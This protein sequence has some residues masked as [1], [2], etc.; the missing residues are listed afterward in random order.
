MPEIELKFTVAPDRAT[1]VEA[2]LRRAGSRLTRIESRYFDTADGRLADARLSL[3]L[4]RAEGAWE[5]T[6]KAAGPVSA[7]RDEETVLRTGDWGPDGPPVDPSL[8][9]G[10]AAGKALAKALGRPAEP[11]QQAY[12]SFVR[13]R[14]IEVDCEGSRVEVAFDQG[15][16][17]SG[18]H[19]LPVCEVEYEL[20]SGAPAA[21]AVLARAGVVEHGM[22]LSTLAK[23][24]RGDRLFRGEPRRLARKGSRPMLTPSLAGP[25]ML[26][27]MLRACLEQVLAN[28]SEIA[29]DRVDDEL[30]HQLR[31]GLRRLRTTM[32]ELGSLAPALGT[33]WELPVVG[34][35]QLLGA[36]RDR[37]AVATALQARLAEAGSP[38]PIL[39]AHDAAP[40]S[41]AAFVRSTA[42][43]TALLEFVGFT[44]ET[45][46]GADPS[47]GPKAGRRLLESRLQKLH[48]RLQ[49]GASDFAQLAPAE[50]HQ[51][52]KRLKRLRYLAEMAGSLY[53]AVRVARYLARLA[54]A[55]DELGRYMDLVVG[56][57]LAA[58]AARDGVPAAW[59]NVGWL[60]AEMPDSVERCRKAL[61]E[62]GRAKPFWT[63]GR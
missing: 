47:F 35:F 2:T 25:D 40:A 8:H 28:A 39:R 49:R 31:I 21:L 19:S 16:I 53:P 55:Q 3:R 4:R 42:F 59:F 34:V 20:K 1:S 29:A 11:L 22:W 45:G 61:V 7:V 32:R 54:P 57:H 10:T 62:A 23:G 43:Q 37:H 17:R 26:R 13:R 52:R 24:A 33:Q 60:R 51:V 46:A 18:G 14:T 5:Q 36:Y 38:A 12:A 41:P 58:D 15:E 44:L 30:V 50:R 27:E 6:L 9:R 56:S 48:V 63:H